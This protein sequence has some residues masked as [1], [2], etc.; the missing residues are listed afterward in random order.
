MTVIV[1]SGS[2]LTIILAQGLTLSADSTIAAGGVLEGAGTISGDFA[3]V[4]QGEILSSD[5]GGLTIDTGSFTNQ[6]T[7]MTGNAPVTMEPSVTVTNFANGT[8]T[9]GTWDL[10]SYNLSLLGGVITTDAAVIN[11]FAT[12][13]DVLEADPGTSCTQPI[14]NTLTEIAPTGLISTYTTAWADP[15]SLNID[16]TFDFD[17]ITN[18]GGTLSAAG[19]IT[20]S[21]FGTL[22]ASGTIASPLTL[23]GDLE[24]SGN[25]TLAGSLS[26]FGSISGNPVNNAGDLVFASPGTVSG[27][28]QLFNAN[29]ITV[30][31]PNAAG[32]V[33]LKGSISGPSNLEIQSGGLEISHATTDDVVFLGPGAL[34]LDN[35][36][37]FTGQIRYLDNDDTI[38]L[39]N[40]IG[41]TATYNTN[42]A[43]LSILNGVGTVGTL[44]LIPLPTTVLQGGGQDYSG[45]TFVAMP[46]VATNST[47]ITF[48]GIVTFP[49]RCFRAGTAIA[50][51]L[52]DVPVEQLSA[53]DEVLSHF[54][55]TRQIVWTGRRTIDCCHHPDPSCVWPIRIA[56]P[57]F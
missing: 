13:G 35:P 32:T 9:G 39:N 36:S 53:G 14:M 57:A 45:A 15:G 4:N 40:V 49:T 22:N 10:S 3:L 5:P 17:V 43:N 16:G 6:G 19:G 24:L 11:Y 21:G 30:D 38:V 55:Q 54:G 2:T 28:V 37:G 7:V 46:N 34:V 47:T 42:N 31:I 1:N 51:P 25:L 8:L 26:G 44:T 48:S 12:G 29:H 52:G 41:N 20:V 27:P 50:T 23:N 56:L 18:L 33:T